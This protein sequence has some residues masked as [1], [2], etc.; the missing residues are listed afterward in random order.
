[1]LP[2]ADF[3]IIT[4]C[5]FGLYFG[6]KW[7][8]AAA[9]GIARDFGLSDLVIGLTIVAI[10]TSTPEFAVTV[11]SAL[12]QE[13]DIAIGN[14][15]GSNMINVGF[16]LGGVAFLGAV[17]VVQKLARRDGAVLIGSTIL[18]VFFFFD[19]WFA[20]W[21]AGIL[22]AILVFYISAL[23][24]T[25][26]VTRPLPPLV[27]TQLG[28]I[29]WFFIGSALVVACSNLFV[30]SATNVAGYFGWTTWMVGVTIVAL[31]TSLPEIMTSSI[32]VGNGRPGISVGNLIGSNLFNLLGVMGLAGVLSVGGGMTL[33]QILIES[34]WTLLLLMLTVLWMMRSDWEISRTEGAILFLLALASWI[35]NFSDQTL[36][37]LF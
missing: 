2:V 35:F 14:V 37:G 9:V 24:A 15:I 12:R 13:I 4:A 34:S 3:A 36:I 20:W 1:M 10:G 31:G 23:I 32:A 29:P 8:V 28:D 7:I 6:A 11:S 22:L 17:P 27:H 30:A 26:D 16:I 25:Q 21:E 33:S 19:G 18:L 5:I